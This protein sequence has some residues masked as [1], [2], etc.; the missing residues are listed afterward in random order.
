MLD[1]FKDPQ[2][3]PAGKG[4]SKSATAP[5]RCKLFMNLLQ[6]NA[7]KGQRVWVWMN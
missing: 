7:E 4:G 6:N 5:S 3:L 2:F 1:S